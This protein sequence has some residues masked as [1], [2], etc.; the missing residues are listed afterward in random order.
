MFLTNPQK[1][2]F[3]IQ[4]GSNENPMKLHWLETNNCACRSTQHPREVQAKSGNMVKEISNTELKSMTQ[5][6][7]FGTSL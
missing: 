2:V 4:S 5:S 1:W 3:D 6:E 7:H